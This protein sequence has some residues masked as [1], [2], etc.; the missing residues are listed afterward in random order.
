MSRMPPLE[1]E[2]IAPEKTDLQQSAEPS[3][4]KSATDPP[5]E[6]TPKS[7]RDVQFLWHSM[8]QKPWGGKYAPPT[9]IFFN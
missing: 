4:K 3:K 5:R 6:A 2:E 9:S 8:A 7:Q 1:K